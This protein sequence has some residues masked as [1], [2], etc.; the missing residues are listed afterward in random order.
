MNAPRTRTVAGLVLSVFAA[1]ALAG[2]EPAPAAP[3][4]TE[5]AAPPTGRT[6]PTTELCV[7]LDV[8]LDCVAAH[9]DA[10]LAA[11]EQQVCRDPLAQ[12]AGCAAVR[13]L[14]RVVAAL[15]AAA[16]VP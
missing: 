14:R 9:I 6:E 15:P 2:S 11:L 4:R 7:E 10:D 13:E 8:Q 16:P 1:A 3:G 12:G 5:P